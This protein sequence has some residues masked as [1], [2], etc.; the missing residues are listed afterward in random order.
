MR[1]PSILVLAAAVALPGCASHS[2]DVYGRPVR[3]VPKAPGGETPRGEL[4]AAQDGRLFLRTKDGVRD[5]D[6]AAVR[7]VRVERHGVARS[8]RR[9]ALIGGAISFVALTASC[10]SVEGNDAGGCAAA[11]G[12][13]GGLTMLTGVLSSMAMESHAEARLS[14][15]REELRAFAR[16]PAGMPREIPP[17]WLSR[18]P[19]K[20][21][22]ARK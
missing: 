4:L 5:F 21:E 22:R 15:S 3:L 8:T 12:L 14:P 10:S 9:F 2:P 18:P 1:R 20:A 11:G 7:E 17:E 19:G 16:F 13:I 6:A